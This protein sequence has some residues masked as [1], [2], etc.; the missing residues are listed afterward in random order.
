MA[1]HGAQTGDGARKGVFGGG[2][3]THGAERDVA[4][5]RELR[6]PAALTIGA[7]RFILL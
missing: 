5:G 7:D 1:R 2:R 3:T 6:P 4:S